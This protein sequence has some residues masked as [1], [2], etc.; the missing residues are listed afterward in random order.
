M[1]NFI[2]DVE[3]GEKPVIKNSSVI[4]LKAED[5]R[6]ILSKCWDMAQNSE[7]KFNG[8]NKLIDMVEK[9]MV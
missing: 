7:D 1:G 4:P 8:I 9:C 5:F 6:E 3:N 2:T